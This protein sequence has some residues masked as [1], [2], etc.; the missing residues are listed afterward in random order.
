MRYS[1]II[2]FSI[3]LLG[4]TGCAQLFQQEVKSPSETSTQ[5]RSTTQESS[6]QVESTS[7]DWKNAPLK[8]VATGKSF[9]ISDFKGKPILI[10]SFAVWCPTCKKQQD[11]I[12]DLHEDVGDS[13]VSIS[14]DTDP[15]EDESQVQEHIDK[16]GFDWYFAVSPI[17]VSQ[18]LIEEFTITVVNA[19]GAPVVLVC[20]DQS[21]TLL[22]TGVKSAD[23]LKQ[24]IEN[25][26]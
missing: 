25:N 15:N 23:D 3:L 11:K 1:K 14:L 24:A 13:V 7:Y 16:Y 5:V 21:A 22:K 2:I 10:E 17:E 26:C 19:P 20:G 6:I 8:D 4:L 9:K 18:A 12:K